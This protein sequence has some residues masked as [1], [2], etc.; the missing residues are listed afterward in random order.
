VPGTV[1]KLGR[2]YIGVYTYTAAPPEG[3]LGTFLEAYRYGQDDTPVVSLP[4]D[5][6]GLT[7]EF[8]GA[9]L[10]RFVETFQVNAAASTPDESSLA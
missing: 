10:E 3:T 6:P 7:K 4:F 2:I 1:K 9:A 8:L 5:Y